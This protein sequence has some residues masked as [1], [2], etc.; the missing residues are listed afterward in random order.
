M[1][2]IWL[3]EGPR[4]LRLPVLPPEIT[5]SVSGGAQRMDLMEIG[6]VILPGKRKLEGLQLASYF[7]ARYDSNCQYRNIPSPAETVK[8][9]EE[10]IENSK[11][12]RLIITGGG[13]TANRLV[14]I[15]NGSFTLGKVPGDISYQLTLTEYRPLSIK[16]A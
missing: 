4:R 8:M 13:F 6:E 16:K 3:S 12:V 14:L 10:W 11:P 7:P 2:E 15:E 9:L 1:L 5:V